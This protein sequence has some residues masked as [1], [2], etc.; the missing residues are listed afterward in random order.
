MVNS[1]QACPRVLV[2]EGA[3]KRGA[4]AASA[5]ALAACGTV[6]VELAAARVPQIALYRTSRLSSWLIRSVLRPTLRHATLPNIL[7]NRTVI[8]ELLFERCN[9]VETANAAIKLLTSP[10]EAAA[11]R[12]ELYPL[13]S[14]LQ[15]E[16]DAGVHVSSAS[17]AAHTLIP[18]LPRRR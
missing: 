18:Y 13:K 15:A 6:N 2:V 9:A 16:D 1:A 4:Y 10:E 17:V 8:P 11:Q 5:L 3:E 12:R 14:M 7:L